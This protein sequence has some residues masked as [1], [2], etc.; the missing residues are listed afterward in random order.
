VALGFMWAR[1]ARVAQDKL[2]AGE[3]DKAFLETKL[4]VGRHYM[5]RLMPGSSAHYHRITAGSMTMMSLAA[6]LF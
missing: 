1:M 2:A 5:E 6:D 4:I 3:G